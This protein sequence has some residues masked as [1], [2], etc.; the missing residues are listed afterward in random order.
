MQWTLTLAFA[1]ICLAMFIG[2][3]V[4]VKS[5][6]KIPQMLI[7]AIIFLIGYWTVF[8]K[9]L[10]T[11]GG[12][13]TIANLTMS[14]ILIHVGTMFDLD[15][16]KKEWR[17]AVTVLAAM[18]GIMV[19]VLAVGMV[20]FGKTTTLLALAP[21]TGGG[22]AALIMNNAAQKAGH[23]ELGLLPMM[24]FIMH[25]FVGFP[26]TALALNKESNRLIKDFR[27]NKGNLSA[28][29]PLKSAASDTAA[30]PSAS[31]KVKLIDRLPKKY[32]TSTFYIT[33]LAVLAIVCSLITQYTGVNVAIVQVV[34][35]ILF[36][37]LGLIDSSPLTKSESNGI[38]LLALFASFMSSL[39]T[40]TIAVLIKVIIQI[41][42]I[43]LAGTIGMG[44]F[45]IPVGK[46]FGYSTFMS[47][48]IGL[49]CYLGFPF[50]YALTNEAVRAVAKNDEEK[51]YLTE[52]LM[53]KMIIAGIVSI[54]IVSS[55]VA[56][57]IAG[58]VF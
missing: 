19:L 1:V 54:S 36:K 31:G 51:T 26:L 48:A 18:I 42:V 15:S 22:M 16:L 5:K 3:V 40:A 45:S 8:P 53:P 13:T 58:F 7:V 56:G 49:N 24:I 30:A 47:F 23:P 33:E 11:V 43:M 2:D 50:N 10:L 34:I 32:K 46:K 6:G 38:L 25:G 41:V 55:I 20:V 35:G 28:S 14:F 37:Q 17:V 52:F 12:V 44:L 29:A 39:A 4:S 21:M 57:V 27:E 9:D